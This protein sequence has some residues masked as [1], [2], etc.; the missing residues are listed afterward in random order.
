MELPPDYYEPFDKYTFTR[1]EE[2]ERRHRFKRPAKD[3]KA[4]QKYKAKTPHPNYWEFGRPQFVDLQGRYYRIAGKKFIEKY[5]DSSL[6][7]YPAPDNLSLQH[8][9]YLGTQVLFMKIDKKLKDVKAPEP[10]VDSLEMIHVDSQV[11]VTCS[12]Y[13]AYVYPRAK[14]GHLIVKNF[15]SF[16]QASDPSLYKDLI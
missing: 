3:I 13:A 15:T 4:S 1:E 6:E 5:I 10:D 11:I 2:K 7:I 14:T 12:V 8:S 16:G 9:E